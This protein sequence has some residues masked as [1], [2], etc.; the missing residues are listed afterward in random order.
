MQYK[1]DKLYLFIKIISINYYSP[2]A[3]KLKY[4]L[5]KIFL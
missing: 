2:I 1:W 4:F 5:H 3:K